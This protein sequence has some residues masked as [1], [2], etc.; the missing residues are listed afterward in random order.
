MIRTFSLTPSAAKYF[1]NFNSLS[2]RRANMGWSNGAIFLMATLV[3]LGRCRAET[4]TP[5]AP[6][7]MT[8]RTWY[9]L[10]CRQLL[11]LVDIS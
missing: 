3:L 5:Y 9:E 4:T 1:N 6:S 8:S 7:P 11:Y 2:V 10:P